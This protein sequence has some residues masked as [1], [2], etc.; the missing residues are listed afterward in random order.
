MAAFMWRRPLN[1]ATLATATHRELGKV[2]DEI[3]TQVG[4]QIIN[5]WRV[6]MTQK[7]IYKVEDSSWRGDQKIERE[8]CSNLN[9]LSIQL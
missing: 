9:C 3:S 8:Y 2:A 6:K 4:V 5:K 1:S 7:K